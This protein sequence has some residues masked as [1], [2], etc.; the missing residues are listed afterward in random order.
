MG[1]PVPTEFKVKAL[2]TKHVLKEAA[3]GVLPSAIIDKPKLGFF[4]RAIGVWLEQQA[5]RLIDQHLLSGPTRVEELVQFQNVHRYAN[6]SLAEQRMVFRI[7]IL[8]LWLRQ[9]ATARNGVL[10]G[11]PVPVSG[12]NV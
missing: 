4:N 7:L 2:T 8:E 3:R 1:G 12:S 5:P 9:A 11:S 10:A 6:G